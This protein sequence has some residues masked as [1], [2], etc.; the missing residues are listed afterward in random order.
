MTISEF[1]RT[2]GE[3]YLAKD[4]ARG[5]FPSYA[6]LVEEIGELA[7][8]LR[9]GRPEELR[10]EFADCLAWLASLAN[11]AGVDLE[12]AAGRYAGA[13]PRCGHC[14]CSCVDASH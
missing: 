12:E 14:P 10:H 9:H 8:A 2:I 13:C 11:M 5:L 7:G 6:W 4:S 1:Q 3:T